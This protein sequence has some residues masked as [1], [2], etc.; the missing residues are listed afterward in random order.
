VG[1]LDASARFYTEVFGGREQARV[2]AEIAGRTIDEILYEPTAPGGDT[3]ALLRF[4]DLPHPATDAVI[5]GFV[6]DDLDAVVARCTAA[7]GTAVQAPTA[8]PEHGVTVAFLADADG[9]LIEV[10]ELLAP[11]SEV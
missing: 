2:H 11:T 7:G 4:E 6:T 1:D 9:H 8:M 3:F 10:V 5:L